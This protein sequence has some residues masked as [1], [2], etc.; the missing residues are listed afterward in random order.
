MVKLQD[1]DMDVDLA[2][3]YPVIFERPEEAWMSS[4]GTGAIPR[5]VFDFYC[6]AKYFSFSSA[7]RFLRDQDRLLFPYLKALLNGIRESF[8]DA[9]ALLGQLRAAEDSHWTDIKEVKGEPWDPAAG[10]ISRR[11]LKY[12]FV[13][14]AGALDQT[15]EVTALLFVDMIPRVPIGRA[16]FGMLARAAKE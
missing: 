12:L 11:S 2:V 1:C 4:L 14:V 5:S 15:A 8:E 16:D 6:A 9:M 3:S 10:Q 7:P 13:E